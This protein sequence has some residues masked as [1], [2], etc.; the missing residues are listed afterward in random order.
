MEI[1][2]RIVT[3]LSVLVVEDDPGLNRLIDKNLKRAGFHTESCLTG[4]DAIARISENQNR[5]IL[6]DYMLSDMTAKDLVETLLKK[7]CGVPFIVM[8]GYGNEKLA[9]QMMKLGARDY[10]VKESDFLELLP[11]VITKTLNALRTEQK[12]LDV[13]KALRRSEKQY[14]D[15]INFLPDATFAINPD[16]KVIAW[17]H[18]IEKMTG[19]SATSMLGKGDYEYALPFYGTRRPILIDLVLRHDK[20]IEKMYSNIYRNEGV[21]IAESID[22]C[23]YGNNLTIWAKAS[24]MVDEKGEIIGAI[25]SIRDITKRKRMEKALQQSEEKYR[26]ILES[27]KEGYFEVDITGNFTFFN[28]SMCKIFGYPREELA[29]MNYRKYMDKKHAW[30]IYRT[31]NQVYTTGI[32]SEACD[33]EIVRKNGNRRFLESS[34]SPIKNTE[35]NAVG[36]RGFVRDITER[37]R[38]EN[39][40]RKLEV[41]LQRADKMEAIGTLAGGV[42]HDLNNVLSGLV[43]YPEL[44]L[45]QIPDE[46]PLRKPL[47]TIQK[48]GEKA[49]AIVQDLLT[50][51]RRGVLTTEAVNLNQVIADH[52]KT[53]EHEKLMLFNPNVHFEVHLEENLSNIKG[54]PHHLSKSIMNLLSNAAEAIHDG[55]KVTLSTKSQYLSRFDAVS[56]N[57]NEGEYVV[58][59]V[60]DEGIGIPQSDIERIFEP[61]YTKKIMGRSGTGLG[62]TVVWG[63]VQDHQGY[64]D[65]QSTEGEG[66]TFILYFPVAE[67]ELLMEKQSIPTA[68]KYM[69]RG[70]TILVVDDVFEQREIA[71]NILHKLGYSVSSVSNGEEAVD[72]MRDHSA[73]LLIL[74]MIM[75]PG[76]DGLETYKRI[77]EYHP[78]QKAI[79]VSGF[80]ETKHVKMAQ[81]LGAGSYIRKPYL[82]ETLAKTVRNELDEAPKTPSNIPLLQT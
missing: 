40:R 43:S 16:G 42:A 59:T 45:M 32:S 71:T 31:I 17:N 79:I 15:I 55:G 7:G 80:S 39:E 33:L 5:L 37:R 68:E 48:S 21:F 23:D 57:A 77:L 82:L 4:A 52:L 76:I 75:D 10:M 51:A 22:L 24:P 34:I 47:L 9:V 25:E 35:G 44:L 65:V 73:N 74:D 11:S 27:I 62:M 58:L 20:Q 36:F 53:P 29:G 60:S 61:F 69:G 38:A 54:S 3:S 13:E 63:T 30:N 72:Y 67:E 46:S 50:L 12:L 64:I 19:V 66:T 56:V 49:A 8:T 6:V 41:K 2:D 14:S 81:K 18:E 26:T 28:D 70:E 1:R 78:F